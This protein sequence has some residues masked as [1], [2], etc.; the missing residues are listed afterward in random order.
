MTNVTAGA[1]ADIPLFLFHLLEYLDVEFEID[2][3][4]INQRWA[5]A[6]S[7]DVWSQLVLK[8]TRGIAEQL[9]SAPRTGVYRFDEDGEITFARWGNDWHSLHDETEAFFLRVLAP[10]DYTYPGA[11]LGMLVA[12]SRVED[13]GG[14]L[15]DRACQWIAGVHSQFAGTPVAEQPVAGALAFTSG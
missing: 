9:T 15:T 4:D 1:Y 11:D 10:G 6:A 3:D 8:D 13:D 14:R 12:R 7:V 2:V 5:Q